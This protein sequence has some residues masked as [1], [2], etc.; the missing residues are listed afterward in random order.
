VLLGN[1]IVDAQGDSVTLNFKGYG[2][3][4][5]FDASNRLKEVSGQT[6]TRINVTGTVSDIGSGIGSV[7]VTPNGDSGKKVQADIIDGLWVARG[8][9]ERGRK[10]LRLFLALSQINY[11]SL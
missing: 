2:P 7:W 10:N 1:S 6:G 9:L 8:V 11:Q 5:V 3:N 4:S